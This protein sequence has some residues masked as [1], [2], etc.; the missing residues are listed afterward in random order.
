MKTLIVMRHATS[1][2]IADRDID[3]SLNAEGMQEVEQI[4]QSL[5]NYTINKVLCSSSLRTVETYNIIKE[6]I[7]VNLVDITPELYNVSEVELL[8]HIMQQRNFIECLLLIGHNPALSNLI[9]LLTENHKAHKYEFLGVLSP[10]EAVVLTF[11]S[12]KWSDISSSDIKIEKIF[13]PIKM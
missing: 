3:R 12:D 11:V 8:E 10:A 4:A 2:N 5:K 7:K 6:H 1:P 13:K 9:T